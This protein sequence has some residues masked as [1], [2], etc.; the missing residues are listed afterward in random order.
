MD[1]NLLYELQLK[2]VELLN[3]NKRIEQLKSDDLLKRLVEEY[4]VLRR[5]YLSFQ[6]KQNE[7]KKDIESKK[8]AI[9]QL[10]DNIRNY[11]GLKYSPEINNAKK[12]KMVE[13]QIMDTESSIKKEAMQIEDSNKKINKINSEL[14]TLKRKLVF[15]KN[16]TEK[17]K[18]ES[19]EELQS[20]DKEQKD[21]VG[22]I[23]DMR[24][25]IDEISLEEYSKWKVRTDDP[26]SLMVSRKCTGCSVDVPS[27]NFEAA[28]AGDIIR[29]ESCG[30][31][32]LY[33]RMPTED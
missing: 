25:E 6:D 26:I 30:R 21:I 9:R 15:I 27:I 1:L 32:L 18:N 12:L 5:Q 13:K 19:T 24:K 16:K 2:E 17:T 14:M 33:R 4:S 7:H 28:R 23:K 3:L 31:V 22:I 8:R 11:E 29:C 10:Q 20:L